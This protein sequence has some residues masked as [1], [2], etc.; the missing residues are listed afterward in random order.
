MA[1]D[2]AAVSSRTAGNSAAL[3]PVAETTNGKVRGMLLDGVAVFRGVRYGASTAGAN[4]FLPPQPAAPWAGIRD[5]TDWSCS[6]PQLTKPTY[7]DPFYAWYAA[8]RDM[9][10]DCL[11]LNVFTPGLDNGRRPVMVWLHGG[12]WGNFASSAPGFDGTNLARAQDVVVVSMNHRLNVFGFLQLDKSHERFAD[13]GSAGVLDL[14]MALRWVRDNA[15]T[16]GGD[17]A[18]VTIFG[19]SGGAAKTAALLAMPAAKGLFHKAIVQSTSGGLRIAGREE[20]ARMAADLGKAM[21]LNA[22]RRRATAEIADAASAVGAGQGAFSISSGGRWPQFRRR[23]FF[24]GGPCAFESCAG[25][26]RDDRYGDH[27]VFLAR[28]RKFSRWSMPM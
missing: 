13:S 6:A 10:E 2:S 16:F 21:E 19:Q 1:T 26:G 7:A 15:A 9:S 8:I 17:P 3:G 28:T 20:A 18:N 27:V 12:G 22:L 23:S 14:V 5:A 24:S 4:R 25:H 11:F